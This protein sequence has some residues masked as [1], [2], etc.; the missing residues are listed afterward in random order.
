MQ[1]EAKGEEL[2]GE[3]EVF[4]H[5]PGAT[6][7]LTRRRTAPR[8]SDLICRKLRPGESDLYRALRLESLKR[9]PDS[10]GS[11][12]WIRREICRRSRPG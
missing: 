1:W 10:F 7:P 9:Y 12:P 8:P 6:T 3:I 11:T 4:E 2:R 5:A